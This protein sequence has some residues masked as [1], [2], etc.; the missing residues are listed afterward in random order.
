MKARYLV[1]S[2]IM[3]TLTTMYFNFQVVVNVCL[4][5]EEVDDALGN[6]VIFNVIIE[7]LTCLK[8]EKSHC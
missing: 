3:N 8:R 2:S 6:Q 1:A 4:V 5:F 7:G